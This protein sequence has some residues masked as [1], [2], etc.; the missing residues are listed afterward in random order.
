[1]A[2]KANKTLSETVE[3]LELLE[4]H[5][6]M[7]K[8][9]Y[10][11]PAPK[12]REFFNAGAT[13]RERMF[14]AGNGVGKS[15][16][17][18]YEDAMHLTGD[19]PDWWQGIRY[20]HPVTCW[21]ACE[22]GTLT[23]DIIQTILCGKFGVTS[24]FGTGFIPKDRFVDKPTLARGVT[25]AFDTIQ[26]AHKTNGVFDGVSTCSFKS[27]EQGRQ[28]FQGENL[29]F[30]HC[31]EEPPMDVYTE[32]LA[33]IRKTDKSRMIVTFTPLHN[34]TDL[35]VWFRDGNINRK[36]VTMSLDEAT[37][38]SEETKERMVSGYPPHEREARRYGIPMLGGGRIFPYPQDMI[39]EPAIEYIPPHWKKIWGVDFGVGH[40]FAAVLALWDVDNDVIHIYHCIRLVADSNTPFNSQPMFHAARMRQAGASVPVAWPHDGNQRE[41]GNNNQTVSSLYKAH[42]LLMLPTHA[43][44]PD[45]GYSTEA[46][47]KEMDERMMGGRFRVASHLSEWWEEYNSYHRDDGKIVKK[48]DD[49]M[50]ATRIAVMAKRFAKPVPLGMWVQNRKGNN[51]GLARGANDN[52]LDW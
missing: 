29:D 49:L 42:G 21:V 25:D 5:K 2:R 39:S 46:G 27:F 44:F 18:G 22:T 20:T 35:I 1:M 30:G 32:F 33:R 16:S 51:T 52:P 24:L 15:L 48:H 4:K 28:K 40:P 47:I 36:T 14:M 13:I 23:R 19:Y 9:L 3:L 37:W 7:N 38:Y 43:T 17:G 6:T 34:I 31:D 11:S 45:G 8:A 50:S 41:I 10:Y 26:V 12:Q